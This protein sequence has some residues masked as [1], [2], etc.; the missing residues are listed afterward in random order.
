MEL[1]FISGIG[2]GELLVIFV[3]FL[4]LFGAKKLPGI[5]RSLGRSMAELQRAAREVREEFLN[6]DRELNKPPAV[7]SSPSPS[8][9]ASPS[10]DGG[11]GDGY[12]GWHPHMETEPFAPPPAPVPE[13]G[14]EVASVEPG[15]PAGAAPAAGPD[16]PNSATEPSDGDEDRPV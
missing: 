8:A 10:G 9:E 3:I 12:D 6:A 14:S 16:G 1:A 5:A 11:Y 13:T 2:G 7:S 4:M 15:G